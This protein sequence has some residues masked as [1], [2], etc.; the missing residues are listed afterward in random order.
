VLARYDV[1]GSALPLDIALFER[2]SVSDQ[3]FFALNGGHALVVVASM[4]ADGFSDPVHARAFIAPP[5]TPFLYAAGTWHA[6]LFALGEGSAFLMGI[7]ESGTKVDFETIE[8]TT[9]LRVEAGSWDA[10]IG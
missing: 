5:Q 6:P 3:A 1:A 4:D 9:T 7:A 10:G 8:L 2:H